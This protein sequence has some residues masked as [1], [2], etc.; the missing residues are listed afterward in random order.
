M[1]RDPNG[2]GSLFSCYKNEKIGLIIWKCSEICTKFVP[3]K[4]LDPIKWAFIGIFPKSSNPVGPT[5]LYTRKIYIKIGANPQIKGWRLFL[6]SQSRTVF[7]LR[8]S[9]QF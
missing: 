1:K 3:N 7:F 4:K 8:E 9:I 6:F 2:Q 5:S